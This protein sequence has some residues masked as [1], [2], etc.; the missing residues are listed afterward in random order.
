MSEKGFFPITEVSAALPLEQWDQVSGELQQLS[1][2]TKEKPFSFWKD[3]FGNTYKLNFQPQH[4][5]TGSREPRQ[6]FDNLVK[7]D[8]SEMAEW[9][10]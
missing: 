6:T 5:T 9:L 2:P 7:V 8:E 1:Q 4:D 10:K 3:T